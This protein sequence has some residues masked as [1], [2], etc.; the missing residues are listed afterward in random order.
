M[1]QER[2]TKPVIAIVIP[3]YNEESVLNETSQQ[4]NTLVEKLIRNNNI[5]DQSFICFIDDGSTDTTWDKVEELHFKNNRI[6]GVKLSR[7][8]GH[9]NALMAGLDSVYEKIDC[10]ISIDADLQDDISVI[11][12]MVEQFNKGF[13]VVYGVRRK[14]ETDTLLKKNTALIFYRL[15]SC[16]GIDMVYNHADFR[17]LSKNVIGHLKSFKEVNLFLRA[18]IPLIGFRSTNVYYDRKVR[19]A[20]TSKYSAGKMIAFALDGI[21]SFS[22]TPL[23]FI[24]VIGCVLFI[25][26][27]ILTAWAFMVTIQHK[28]IPGWASTVLPIYFI[29]GIQLLSIGIIG[30][31]LG[32]IYKEV[33]ARPR[34]I[35][36]I[37]LF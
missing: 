34:Y 5:S 24:T 9:Q 22:I 33:K 29:G 14:R 11:E 30:E 8:A 25:S 10:A 19:Y 20:G 16:F 13:E 27:L 35:K 6:K 23:R 12:S 1:V 4:L 28:S 15:M 32:K 17:L 31:Y 2:N 18:M 21:T 36:D 26:S 3:C 7:N 37:E